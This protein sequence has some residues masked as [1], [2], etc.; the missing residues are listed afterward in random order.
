MLAYPGN[1]GRT[2]DPFR[3]MR[4]MQQDVNR[5]MN[6]LRAPHNV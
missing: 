3:Q 1:A 2:F 4:L 5:V 6:N